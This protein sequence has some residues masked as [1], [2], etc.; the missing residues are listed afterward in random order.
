M[1]WSGRHTL[2]AGLVLI[3]LTNAIALGGAWWNRSGGPE[4][5]LRLSERDLYRVESWHGNREN[6]GLSLRPVWRLP[7]APSDQ[8]N[9][10]GLRFTGIGGAPSW[11]DPA[12]MR[13]LGFAAPVATLPDDRR[14]ARYEKQ[15]SREVLLVLELDGPAYRRALELVAERAAR[16]EAELASAP[17]SKG[18]DE[19]LKNVRGALEWERTASSRLFVIDA[20]LDAEALRAKY[21]DR[22]RYAIVRGEVRPWV[23]GAALEK[24]GGHVNSLS[25]DA[26]NVPLRLRPVL[27]DARLAE[28]DSRKTQ[29][30]ASVAWGR[31]LEPWLVEFAARK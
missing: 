22:T 3:A 27:A 29:F 19:R 4:A 6:S 18:R 28:Y 20:G 9:I 1:K 26:I 8:I 21:S 24:I 10:Y 7:L 30:E 31:R 16:E 25:V 12:K 14:R 11:L 17:A 5:T 2:V 13:E 23:Y 15:L